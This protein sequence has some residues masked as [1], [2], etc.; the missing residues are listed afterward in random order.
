[1]RLG[2]AG[3]APSPRQRF[4]VVRIG[5]PC[6]VAKPLSAFDEFQGDA[7]RSQSLPRLIA[8]DATIRE[9]H[10]SFQNSGSDTQ[11][12]ANFQRLFEAVIGRWVSGEIASQDVSSEE[13]AKGESVP[14]NAPIAL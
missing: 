9:L 4:V 7:V 12:R 8:N 1:M 10:Q 14:Y 3:S 5:L 13:F 11:Q 6:S 2:Q